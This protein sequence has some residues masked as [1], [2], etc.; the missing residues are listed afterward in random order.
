MDRS[1]KDDD[2]DFCVDDLASRYEGYITEWAQKQCH[3]QVYGN[4]TGDTTG[5]TTGDTRQRLPGLPP[6]AIEPNG[7]IQFLPP[8]K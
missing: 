3:E 7:S 6:G 5:N 2:Y 4:T 8:Q 1:T